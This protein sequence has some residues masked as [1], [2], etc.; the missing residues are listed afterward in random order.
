[1]SQFSYDDEE[2]AMPYIPEDQPAEN[3]FSAAATAAAQISRVKQNHERELMA[4]DGVEGVGLGRNQIGDDVIVVYLRDAAVE[5]RL[6]RQ[7]EGFQVKTEITGI[8][9]AY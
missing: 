2:A 9:D 7:I 5:S 4:I 1:M 6:P 8:I 3:A